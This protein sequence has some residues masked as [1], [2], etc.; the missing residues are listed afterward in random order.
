VVLAVDPAVSKHSSADQSALVTL[1]KTAHNEIHCLEALGRRVSAPELINLIDEAYRRWNPEVI[2]FESNAA[3]A[4]ICDLL[5]R[6]E[7]F[8]PRLKKVVQTRDK[9]S[10]VHAF[11]VPVENGTF[12]LRGLSGRDE[13]GGAARAVHPSQQAL[14]D[15]MTTF[16]FGEHDDLLDAA[17]MGTAWLGEWREPRVW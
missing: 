13:A 1:G 17:A 12:R 10:R 5:V 8:G 2:L 11:S 3:F 7:A 6:Q 16:P 4:G 15:E 9:L 14:Y